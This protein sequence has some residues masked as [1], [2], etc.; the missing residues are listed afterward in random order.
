M[1]RQN[2]HSPERTC[3]GCGKRDEKRA[4]V[5]LAAVRNEIIID[6]LRAMAGRGG[7]LHREESCLQQ[8]VRS[9]VRE[10]RSVRRQIPLDEREQIA[11]LI[12]SAA[13]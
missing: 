5:R 10:F 4:M 12:R 8:F 2:R 1:R 3:L 11:K 7:Y 9:R 6:K 13:G